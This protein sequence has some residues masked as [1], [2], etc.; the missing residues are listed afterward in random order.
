M[1][2]RT[3]LI[4]FL[5]LQLFS[6]AILAQENQIPK[7]QHDSLYVSTA[8]LADK[9]IEEAYRHLGVRYKYGAN[10]P[11]SFDCT[12]FT[13]YVY[14][15]FGFKLSRSS[16]DQAT[17][18]RPVEGSFR[19]LQKGDIL[20]FGSRRNK[21]VIGHAGIFIE[22]TDS[23]GRD[24]RFIHAS[25]KRGITISNYT[26]SYYTERFL[27][28]RR[29]LPDIL[30]EET[31]IRSVQDISAGQDTVYVEASALDRQVVLLESGRWFYID[32]NGRMT[33]PDSSV[34]IILDGNGKWRQVSNQGHKIPQLSQANQ[35]SAS[36]AEAA[37]ETPSASGNTKAD[38]SGAVYHTIKTGDTLY[39]IARRYKVSMDK[40]CQLN[41]ITR[42]TVLHAGR[43]LRVK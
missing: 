14:N 21:K 17:D 9:I 8:E 27:G 31:A 6:S 33:Q 3:I 39:G 19:N 24:F 30:P 38:T 37:T 25:T 16:K 15:K 28:A 36:N 26:E 7:V 43:K 13:C 23:T 4:L 41:G 10:G 12:G 11:Q 34:S 2:S 35:P 18:G 5:C 29:V 1:I 32:A 40:I 42:K 20:I 22:L